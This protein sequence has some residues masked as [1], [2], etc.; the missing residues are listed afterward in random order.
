MR[1][2]VNIEDSLLRRAK[3]Q[4]AA[5]D[6]TLSEV[7]EEA[8]RV[9]FASRPASGDRRPVSLVTWGE[10]GLRHGLDLSDNAAVRDAMDG[11]G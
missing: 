7:V 3:Q 11:L 8:L 4:A 5:S 9:S 10:G 2:T 6:H 1:T